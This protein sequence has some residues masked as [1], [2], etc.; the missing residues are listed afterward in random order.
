MAQENLFTLFTTSNI[1]EA[2]ILC[3][4]LSDAGIFTHML[5]RQTSSIYPHVLEMA[6]IRI[7]IFQ[8]DIEEAQKILGH[9]LEQKNT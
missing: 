9:F 1:F 2:Q 7:Q 4:M 8:R 5:D 6:Q 3:S